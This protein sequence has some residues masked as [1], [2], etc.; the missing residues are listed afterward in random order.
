VTSLASIAMSP[1]MAAL[2]FVPTK[3][4]HVFTPMRALIGAPIFRQFQIVAACRDFV[5]GARLLAL[6]SNDLRQLGRVE[7]GRRRSGPRRSCWQ[8]DSRSCR[9][10]GSRRE[11][12]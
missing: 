8:A 6:D 10:P 3:A 5:D 12:D 1:A 2:S 11:R 9:Q 7:R 4:A